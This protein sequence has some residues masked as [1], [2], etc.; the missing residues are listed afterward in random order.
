MAKQNDESMRNCPVYGRE[1]DEDLCY[2][3]IQCLC[4]MFKTSSLKEV[5]EIEDI[6]KAR[7]QCRG[8]SYSKL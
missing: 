8:C 1:I 6:E 3:T 2:E 7:Q 5:D 4:G